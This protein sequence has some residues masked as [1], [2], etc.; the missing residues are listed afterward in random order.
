MET[1]II[2][3]GIFSLIFISISIL[4]GIRVGW[5]YRKNKE[6]MYIYVGLVWILIT[7]SWW[8]SAISFVIALI[9]NTDGLMSYPV[10][11]LLIGNLLMPINQL[12]WLSL[13]MSLF[14]KE[15][16]KIIVGIYAIFTIVFEILLLYFAFTDTL[17]IGEVVSIVDVEYT[18][19]FLVWIAVNLMVFVVPGFIFGRVTL[20]SSQ[21]EHKLKGKIL[22][23]AFTLFTIG[24]LLDAAS[25]VP[26]EFLP[27]TRIILIA[28]AFC[29]YGGFILPNW[30]KKLFLKKNTQ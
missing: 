24:A 25:F 10:I 6:R 12:I 8:S 20:K 9:T 29:Y 5:G 27:V 4:V 16:Q 15:K 23:V 3:N 11:Y 21:P 28:A 13:M 14:Y 18:P 22:I 30:M 2:V 17:V 1:N 7:E 26:P 19:L